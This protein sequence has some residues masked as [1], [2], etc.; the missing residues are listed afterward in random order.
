M[1]LRL[2]DRILADGARASNNEMEQ[3]S[4]EKDIFAIGVLRCYIAGASQIPL[5]VNDRT[6]SKGQ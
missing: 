1:Y 4:S 3:K 6:S 2:L 5:M